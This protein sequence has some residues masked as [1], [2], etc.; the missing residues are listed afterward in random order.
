MNISELSI[1]MREDARDSFTEFLNEVVANEY[2]NLSF[3]HADPF[4]S[5]HTEDKQL[6]IEV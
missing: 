4:P 1:M 6:N 3:N 5:L 2:L